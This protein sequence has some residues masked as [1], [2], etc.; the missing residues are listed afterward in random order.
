VARRYHAEGR[1][2]AS[3][4]F[5]RGGGDCSHA[6][7]FVTS[8]ARQL[9]DNKALG[10]HQRIRSSLEEHS[11]IAKQT[12][13]DQWTQL[14]VQP[15][16]K[17]EKSSDPR[18]FLVV[19][20][21]LDECEE[22]GSIGLLLRLLPQIGGCR[23][24]RVRI[25][26][27]SRPETPIRHG[28]DRMETATHQGFVLHRMPTEVSDRDIKVYLQHYFSM[29]A[30][31]RQLDSC[32]P[33]ERIL[34]TMVRYAQ[35]LF[36]WAATACRFI[37]DGKRF[38]EKRLQ[39]LLGHSAR[40]GSEPER[41]LD[42][43]YTTILRASVPET[44]SEEEQKEAYDYLRLILG[45][46][47][48]LFS[49]LSVE[50]LSKLLAVQ[51]K[52]IT[53]TI[54]ELHSILDV[55]NGHNHP[56]RL[57]HDSFRS[58]LLNE[59]RCKERAMIVDEQQAHLQL[60]KGCFEV[61]S[62]ILKEDVC[63]LG[64]PGV[65]ASDINVSHLQKYLSP[66]AQYAC[67]YWVRH[68]I[69]SGQ[70]LFDNGDIH[71][72][73]RK[74]FLHWGEAMAWMGKT[75]DAIEAMASLE[76]VTE[77]RCLITI[78]MF[79]RV[80]S[81]QLSQGEEHQITHSLVH[82]CKRFLMYA[83]HGIEQSPLQTYVSAA[84]F[85]P[86][87]SV[88]R[89]MVGKTKL[90]SCVER[91][92]QTPEYWSALLLVLEGHSGTVN[93]VQFSPDGSKLASASDDKKVIVWDPSTGARLHTLEGH[94]GMVSAVQFSPDGSK[95]ASAS[96]DSK[97]IVWDP[98][99][100]AELQ[101]LEGHSGMVRAVQFSPDNSKLAS[102][103]DD[104]RVI[105]WDPSTGAQLHTLESHSGMVSAIQFSPD[106]SKLASASDDSRVI[107]WDPSTG[108]RLQTL[109]GHSGMVS[110]VQFSPDGSKLV[111]ASDD[112]RLIVWDPST[113]AKL[114]TLESHWA[115][116]R[117]VQFSP[118]GSKLASVSD[119]RK[120]IVWD[121]ST[122][123]K[124]HTLRRHSDTIRDVQFSPDGSKL[125]S[126][127]DDSKVIVWDP[128]TG[129]ELQTLEGHS[130][131]VSAI[132]FSPDGSK[133]A[134]VSDDR[135]V[136]VW[137]PS[138][139]GQSQKLE[140]HSGMVR[141]VQFS[142]D[143]SKLASVSDDRK[144]IVWDSGTGAPSHTLKDHSDVVRVV[145]FSPDGRKLASASDDGRVLVWNSST[146]V[147]L[148]TLEPPHSSAISAVQFS[149]DGSK[150]A[151]ISGRVVRVQ[152]PIT[153][154]N[155]HLWMNFGVMLSAMH[156]SP[157]SSKLAL[158][159]CYG[160]VMVWNLSTRAKLHMLRR[161]SGM[162]RAVQFSPDGSKLASASD[163]S[164][165][166]VWDP[167]T[168]A[169]LQTLEGH[170]GMVTAIKFSPDGSKLASAS[171]DGKILLW[172][173]NKISPVETIDERGHVS[174]LAF[175]PDG[176]YLKTNTSSFKLKSAVEE[177]SDES[178]CYLNLQVQGDWILRHGHKTIWLPPELRAFQGAASFP[179][180]IMA[181]GHSSGTVS[182]WEMSV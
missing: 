176:F 171:D 83:R 102:A 99:T 36:I 161:H 135:K 85:A 3:F 95:L 105:V 150:L 180:A 77:V 51:S 88:I 157:D 56:L 154:E 6:G 23:N 136:I 4:F 145:Q 129:A 167:S 137:D 2:A 124:V 122:G 98:S 37:Q 84:L 138:T 87:G 39:T 63:G 31:E 64:A 182:F 147:R 168:G 46:I 109:E 32:W 123:A 80:G 74:H 91:S 100:G 125:A 34:T 54:A 148:H 130:G 24:I 25:L 55:P 9:A 164:K 61:M 62:S 174:D 104:S 178:A 92:P 60:A 139:G 94:S 111:S 19:I 65:L 90:V 146:W 117:V 59:N 166:I 73:L 11:Q 113:G 153:A 75:S 115:M 47:V 1:L 134:S 120:V 127:S 27:T 58:F 33:G 177:S 41:H 26:V 128:S 21:A 40:T 101:T 82:D 119:D 149:P 173:L 72:F 49:A 160:H 16:S 169:E 14:V 172:D 10:M 30:T 112:S 38:A 5:A 35:G 97:V 175:S 152:D 57:H 142:P 155:L 69:K 45:S 70:L 50:A 53:E 43:I 103:S 89:R 116:I 114:H 8:I 107:V 29:I 106:G 140:G 20:D 179:E 121:P 78:V 108:A 79:R 67:L 151:S 7:L 86:R 158:A 68:L 93:S 143:G 162:V 159:S 12:L 18:T 52:D 48:I 165:V 76:S 156:F 181:L 81:L 96:D 131:M 163:D 13:Q 66:E 141:V 126:A 44:Y 22:E 170:S 133:L 28:F 42:A 15:L 110:A 144:V 132:K 17:H 118:D 71:Q